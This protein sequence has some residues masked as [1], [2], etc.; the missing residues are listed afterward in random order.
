M[1]TVRIVPISGARNQ[2]RANDPATIENSVDVQMIGAIAPHTDITLIIGTS[3]LDV[4]K[5]AGDMNPDVIS[6]SW[7][8]REV[9]APPSWISSINT[10]L[11]G[12]NARGINICCSAGD[13]GATDN[14]VGLSVDFPGASPFVTCCGGTSLICPSGVYD[15]NTVE[16]VWNDNP[17]AAA[18]G[19][20]VS[21]VFKKPDY[22][23]KLIPD[24]V[25]T[26]RCCPDTSGVADG[27]T[28][29]NFQVGGEVFPVG[30]TSIV[31]PFMAALMCIFDIQTFINPFLYKAP[32][33][34]CFHD[35][36]SGNNGG[37]FQAGEGYDQ[38]SGLGSVNASALLTFLQKKGA[39]G[40]QKQ[41]QKQPAQPKQPEETKKGDVRMIPTLV[42]FNEGHKE[43]TQL[44]LTDNSNVILY[45]LKYDSGS[46]K[47]GRE[48]AFDFK[49]S[50][51][52]IVHVDENGVL[53]PI[54]NGKCKVSVSGCSDTCVVTVSD[55]LH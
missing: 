7:G 3:F 39:T 36:I 35:I 4:L 49:S 27:E 10:L 20:G 9:T 2:P 11:Q 29:V 26:M 12:L 25:S 28:G 13:A 23:Q 34:R 54:A 51:N 44:Y 24:S 31:S 6:I 18:T 47:R 53:Y 17:T 55:L 16:T 52:G 1:A 33:K 42:V 48:Q 38:C 22:Q 5:A 43:P 32:R 37:D 41:E 45:P 8:F 19:G 14:G 46:R 50:D 15:D 30:G 21:T 40:P